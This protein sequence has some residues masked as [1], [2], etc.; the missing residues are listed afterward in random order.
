MRPLIKCLSL[1]KTHEKWCIVV[2]A[3]VLSASSASPPQSTVFTHVLC[4][5][6]THHLLA[7][8]PAENN[9]TP[10]FCPFSKGHNTSPPFCLG[11]RNDYFQAGR[12]NNCVSVCI[13]VCM[14]AAEL[15]C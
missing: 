2:A 5:Y 4:S 9:L 11:M 3:A 14:H 13:G 12:G 10:G 1:I 6:F 7:S 15:F 8:C